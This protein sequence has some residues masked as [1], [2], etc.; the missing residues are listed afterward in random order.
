MNRAAAGY[1]MLLILSAVDGKVDGR[2]DKIIRSYLKEN[3]S[4]SI[5]F[6]KEKN[7]IG[8]LNH[9]DYA[10]HFNNAMNSFYMHSSQP[11][12]NHFL[13]MATRLVIADKKI[14][15]KENLYLKELY[16]A[17]EEETEE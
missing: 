4:E 15:P 13:D 6:D 2:E 16:F 8:E 3:F 17:W 7:L 1:R 14:S 5:N 10:I 11:E 9:E 12:R